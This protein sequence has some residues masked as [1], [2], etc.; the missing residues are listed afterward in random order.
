MSAPGLAVGRNCFGHR[1]L[2]AIGNGPE[3]V[4]DGFAQTF[5]R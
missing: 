2:S 3:F 5:A 1:R 4:N